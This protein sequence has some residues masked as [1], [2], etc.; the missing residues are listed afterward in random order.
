LCEDVLNRVGGPPIRFTPMQSPLTKIFGPRL[1]TEDAVPLRAELVIP[2]FIT[3]SGPYLA[4]ISPGQD[5]CG[6]G[7]RG[8]AG[9]LSA[10]QASH[11]AI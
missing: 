5:L 9:N 1:A 2:I 4:V 7:R 6:F 10:L 11:R 8:L 3:S